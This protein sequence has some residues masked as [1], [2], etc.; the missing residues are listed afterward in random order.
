MLVIIN[1]KQLYYF[2]RRL[3]V[4]GKR[5]TVY[6]KIVSPEKW[7]NVS[8]KNKDLLNEFLNYLRSANKSPATIAQYEAQLRTF[9]V[10]VS[11]RCE[12]KFFIDLK[13]R[14]FVKYFGYL[15]NEMEVSTNRVCSM[16]AVLSSL[17]NF[18]ERILDDDYPTFKNL[19]KVLE[20]VKKTAIREKTVLSLQDVNECLEKLVADKKYQVACALAILA[21]SGARKSEL[22]QFK[23]S[24]FAPEHLIL[25]GEAYQ[26]DKM[27]TKGAGKLG[28]VIPRIVFRNI[29]NFEK[30]LD[31]WLKQ[32][33]E[34][35][36]KNEYLFVVYHDGNYDQA[37]VSTANS[38]AR[39]IERYLG[40]EFYLHSMRH[41]FTT[42]LLRSGFSV[43]FVQKVQQWSSADLVNLYNDRPASE[44]L[45]ESMDDFLKNGNK[46][47]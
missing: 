41:A 46:F 10:F 36:I 1:K 4:L 27:R 18:I 15:T 35:G 7:E 37:S 12:N 5:S 3:I 24:D 9:F 42:T 40:Q 38:F 29:V 13:K 11:E 19:V 39:T 16:R 34:L 43:Q 28:K 44:E 21:S 47:C 31:L 17:S 32:R 30:Y 6:H 33:E 22:I 25:K 20:P 8:Q 23:V 26:S 14:D 2:G 45:A